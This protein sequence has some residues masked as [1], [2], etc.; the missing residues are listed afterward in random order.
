MDFNPISRA[1][2]SVPV[3][4]DQVA[5]EQETATVVTAV[6]ALN[7]SEFFGSD[8]EL[9]F[10]RDQE[11]RRPVIQI[12]DRQTGEILQEIPAKQLMRML[13]SM[14]PAEKAALKA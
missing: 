3:H 9:M 4:P 14:S 2:L 6:R 11:T 1:T 12:K 13:A 5:R 10:V 7:K 8:R